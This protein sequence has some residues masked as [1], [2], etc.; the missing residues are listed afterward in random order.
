MLVEAA[1]RIQRSIGPTDIVGRVGGDEFAVLLEHGATASSAD[2]LTERIL[3]GLR[4]PYT[5]NADEAVL[6]A[7]AGVVVS[8]A[9]GMLPDDLVRSAEAA[10][11]AAKRQG[12][13]RWVRMDAR[14]ADL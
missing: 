5:V 1:A 8:P 13:D 9:A 10:M 3:A 7:S 14:A 11:H 6:S 12:R 2:A 4:G